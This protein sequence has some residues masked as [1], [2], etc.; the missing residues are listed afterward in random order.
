[1]GP[2]K[3]R[4]FV[5]FGV[6]PYFKSI[7]IENIKRSSCYIVSFD[8]SLND[9][10]QSCEM[11]LLLRY[12]HEVDY[13][14]EVKYLDSEF[15]GHGTSKDIQKQLNN[16]IS[17]LDANQFFQVRMDE[18]NANLKFL[19]LIQQDREENHGRVAMKKTLWNSWNFLELD[20]LLE[21][22]SWKLINYQKLL[23]NL[24][25]NLMELYVPN[26]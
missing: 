4:Y 8:E 18:P 3:L 13:K 25:K 19:Q 22:H 2:T 5:N 24:C 23:E 6:D 14:V 20:L 7:L 10:A 15:G 12:C 1:M 26:K 16:A 21:N 9:M 11:D 17:D